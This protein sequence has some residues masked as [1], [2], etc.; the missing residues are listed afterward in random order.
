MVVS[1]IYGCMGLFV[2]CSAQQRPKPWLLN[3]LP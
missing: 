2:D 3:K 1:I